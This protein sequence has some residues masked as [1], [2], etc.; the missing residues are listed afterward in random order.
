M[1]RLPSRSA[2]I[3]G[4]ALW[5]SAA[6]LGGLALAFYLG[7]L[8]LAEGLRGT[9]GGVLAAVAVVDLLLGAWFFRSSLSS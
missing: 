4:L 8:P 5:A 3:I 2:R 6:V 9:L 1:A 7:A